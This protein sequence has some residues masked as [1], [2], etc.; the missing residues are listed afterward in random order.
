MRK[1]PEVGMKLPKQFFALWKDGKG[2]WH[3]FDTNDQN[4]AEKKAAINDGEVYIDNRYKAKLR[5]YWFLVR[6]QLYPN[7]Y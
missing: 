6:K 5:L 2:K 7:N 3:Q 4:T 1:L